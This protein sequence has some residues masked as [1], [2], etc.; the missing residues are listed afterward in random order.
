[1]T[2]DYSQIIDPIVPRSGPRIAD[3]VRGAPGPY[4]PEPDEL[5]AQRAAQPG[6]GWPERQAEQEAEWRKNAEA[7]GLGD[8]NGLGR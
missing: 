6:I 8:P 3:H 5:A 4:L 2:A 7:L 1:V